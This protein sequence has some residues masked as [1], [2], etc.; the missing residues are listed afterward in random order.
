[1]L[2][3]K[4]K[5]RSILPLRLGVAIGSV[6]ALYVF[7]LGVAS[8]TSGWGAPLV[9]MLSSLYIGYDATPMGTVIGAL[10][11][12]GDGFIFGY[13]VACIYNMFDNG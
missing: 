7:I 1:M 2:G 9:E 4:K 13:L 11:A 10:W 12:F 8:F 3:F 6:C 5:K